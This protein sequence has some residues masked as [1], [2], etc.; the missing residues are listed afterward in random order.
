MSNNQ[1]KER[2]ARCEDAISILGAIQE[3]LN[4]FSD[5]YVDVDVDDYGKSYGIIPKDL[6]PELSSHCSL[7]ESFE[8]WF[9]QFR[10]RLA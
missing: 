10:E 7:M 2:I 1:F 5:E 4:G 9:I 8:D 6:V 3:Y